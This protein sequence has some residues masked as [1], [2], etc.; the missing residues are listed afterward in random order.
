MCLYPKEIVNPRYLKLERELYAFR[1]AGLPCDWLS[2]TLEA[3][4]KT[5]TVPCGKCVE[6]CAQI[7][8]E[9]A[10][11][12]RMEASLYSENCFVT[13]TYANSD[14]ELNR[15]DFQL[16]MKSLRKDVFKNE[17]LRLRFFGCG[18]YGER[19]GR[20]H[21]H[22][23]LFGWQP[24]DLVF[25]KYDK[26]RQ[27]VYKSPYLANIWKRGFI[28]VSPF[29][30]YHAVYSS[31]YMQKLLKCDFSDKNK[32]PF[33]MMSRRPAIG[34]SAFDVKSLED[35]KIYFDGAFSKVP[36]IFVTKCENDYPFEVSQ[37][38]AKRSRKS[39]IFLACSS[40]NDIFYR[41]KKSYDFLHKFRKKT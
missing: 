3:I 19:K 12:C 41:R 15:R 37:L 36:R 34:W 13:L 23:C 6:C 26:V 18:E 8:R 20:P 4:D 33:R 11:R 2:D 25:Y 28:T 7:S 5:I 29:K 9:W 10:L 35:D 32:M 31:L 21:F 38:K 24:K 1:S 22:V 40:P 14:G 16:F 17:N 27:P 39:D 30:P